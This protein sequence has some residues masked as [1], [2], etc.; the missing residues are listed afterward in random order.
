[1]LETKSTSIALTCDLINL[2]SVSPDDAGCQKLIGEKLS[3]IGFSLEHLR[4]GDVDNLWARRGTS[5][6]VF[7]FAGHTDVVPAGP[8]D[9]WQSPPFKATLRDGHVY[10]RGAC[11]MKGCIAAMIDACEKFVAE[12]PKHK[13]S[14]AFLITS[15][16]E[17]AAVN[18]TVKVVETLEARKEKIDWC[19]VGEPSCV[20]T[21]GDTIKVG[22]RGS[23]SGDLTVHGVQGHVAYPQKSAN[24]IHLFSAAMTELCQTEWDR[25]NEYFPPTSFQIS[26][27][28]A[29]TG[30]DNVIPGDLKVLFNFRFSSEQ[31]TDKLK[32]RVETIL[33]HHQLKYSL[34]WRLSGNPFL[35]KNSKLAAALQKSIKTVQNIN[36]ELTTT[37]GTSDG[38]FIA[39]TGCEVAEFGLINATIHKI[40]ECASLS[41]LD[42]LSE[43]YKQTLENLLL[44]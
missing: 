29:G 14:I 2:P 42:K 33:Q 19:L 22:R 18:G 25:G 16:E 28:N 43:I 21:L 11:D 41:D 44:N 34:T 1:M 27:I 6:P 38:R 39:T 24:P 35:T 10:G 31:T 4:F 26:N 23:F 9:Q 8:K 17:A 12:H 32:T 40:N 3:A 37:G 7:V 5:S 15:D 13:G 20:D 30:A 36:S